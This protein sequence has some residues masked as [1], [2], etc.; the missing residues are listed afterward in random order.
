MAMDNTRSR[1]PFRA[2]RGATSVELNDRDEI[3]SA[4]RELLE[5]VIEAN[6]LE[7]EEIV[8]IIFT[9]TEELTAAFPA[10]AAR[11]LGLEEVALLCCRELSI[12]GM[13]PMCIRILAH[14]WMPDRSPVPV[15][16]KRAVSLRSDLASS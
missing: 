16:L 7:K 2:I 14:A 10:R 5:E 13:L 15:Y 8:S 12:D 9:S 3:I 11:E 4:T 6:S 1:P